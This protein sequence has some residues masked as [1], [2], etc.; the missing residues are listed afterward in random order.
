[1]PS[2][3]G[4]SD[5]SQADQ[6]LFHSTIGLFGD[7]SSRGFSDIGVHRCGERRLSIGSVGARAVVD[8]DPSSSADSHAVF[9]C[10]YTGQ[11]AETRLGAV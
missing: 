3:T 8:F 10:S 7:G 11:F 1:M 9:L 4:N 6:S 5:I 2:T